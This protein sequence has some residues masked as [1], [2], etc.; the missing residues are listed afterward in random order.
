MMASN[1]KINADDFGLNSSVNK[2]IIEAFDKNYINSTTLMANMP[3]FNEAIDIINDNKLFKKVG[4]HLVL[5]EGVAL[6]QKAKCLDYLFRGKDSFKKHMQ[7]NL[8]FLDKA[9]K[10]VIYK[11]LAAQ[12]EK[13]Q[14][15]GIE[16]THLDSHHHV[17]EFIGVTNILLALK[18][19]YHIRSIRILNNLEKP[20]K[21]YK[22]L[23]R[24]NINLYLKAKGANNSDFFGN[25]LDFQTTYKKRPSFIKNSS[26]EIMVH[27]DY[28]ANGKLIDKIN[29]NLINFSDLL[30]EKLDIQ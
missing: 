24:S 20:D 11:E 5:T 2:A 27:P 9:D 12:I 15:S 4:V 30:S 19:Q 28:T 10:Q 1:I 26:I 17:H 23:Y 22:S 29:K 8:F 7:E 13:V 14:N 16:I 3:G 18:K 25:Q 21:I 6:T